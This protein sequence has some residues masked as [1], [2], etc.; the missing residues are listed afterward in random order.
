MCEKCRCTLLLEKSHL[1]WIRHLL[2]MHPCPWRCVRFSAFKPF[3]ITGRNRLKKLTWNA[4]SHTRKPWIQTFASRKR[5]VLLRFRHRLIAGWNGSVQTCTRNEKIEQ[6]QLMSTIVPPHYHWFLLTLP[7]S[8]LPSGSCQVGGFDG[9]CCGAWSES[10]LSECR[11]GGHVCLWMPQ[12]RHRTKGFNM[13]HHQCG[14]NRG[15]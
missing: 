15:K 6:E 8:C 4:W 3:Y 14:S 5:K 1:V 2:R 12:S 11:W 7:V 10:L 13:P 9:W